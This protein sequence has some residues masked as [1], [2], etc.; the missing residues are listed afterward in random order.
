ME[1]LTSRVEKL[2]RI[3]SKAAG[4]FAGLR[5]VLYFVGRRKRK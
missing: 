4:L 2:Y 5:A 1:K 3:F